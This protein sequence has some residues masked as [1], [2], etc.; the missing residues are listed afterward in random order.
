[1]D[2]IK[3]WMKWFDQMKLKLKMKLDEVKRQDEI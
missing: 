2:E 1:M 3:N